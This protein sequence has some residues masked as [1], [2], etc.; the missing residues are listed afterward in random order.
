MTEKKKK[1]NMPPPAPKGNK[2]ALGNNGGRPRTV[3]PE[4]YEMIELG[5]EMV[6]WVKKNDPLQIFQWYSHEK[7]Y[8]YDEFDTMKKRPEFV[9]YYEQAMNYIAL[10]YI[11]GESERIKKGI[12]ERFIRLFF[13]DVKKEENELI[14]FKAREE[15]KA[16]EESALQ[17][18][19]PPNQPSISNEDL[20]IRLLDAERKLASRERMIQELIGNKEE[21]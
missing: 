21:E 16:K 10:K 20:Q 3:S 2:Y 12:S 8:T 11:D 19:V 13:K 5:K 1:K 6:E 14:S 17:S 7:F 18:Q 15:L 4:P 9:P